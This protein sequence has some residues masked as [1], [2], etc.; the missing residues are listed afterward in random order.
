MKRWLSERSKGSIPLAVMKKK[1]QNF[2]N[3]DARVGKFQKKV[4][5]RWLIADGQHSKG[6]TILRYSRNASDRNEPTRAI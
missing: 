5:A 4:E 6:E 2:K 1:F 3:F